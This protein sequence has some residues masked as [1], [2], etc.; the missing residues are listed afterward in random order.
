VTRLALATLLFAAGLQAEFTAV[1]EQD[2]VLLDNGTD[3]RVSIAPEHGGELSGIEIFFDGAWR[4]VVYRAD[5][6]S[7]FDG[8]RGKAPFLWPAVGRSLGPDDADRSYR[9]GERAYPMPPHGFARDRAWRVVRHGAGKTD[10]RA[11][12]ALMSDSETRAMYPFDFELRVE[13]RLEADRLAIEYTVHADAANHGPMPFCI[14]N[15]ITF[16]APLVDGGNP[17]DLRFVT[18][19]PDLLLREDDR[20]F[21]GRVGPSPWRGEQAVAAL[22][23][24]QAVSLGGPAGPAELTLTDPSGLRLTLRHA[25]SAEP[26]S[27]AI[28]FNLWSDTEEGF[29]SP[30]PWLGTQ[31][32]LNTGYGAVRLEPGALWSWRIEL[33]PSAAVAP[34]PHPNEVIP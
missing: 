18:D 3:L 9:I 6:Y 1:A 34:G 7:P 27:P 15:H 14:G 13:Y 20:T 31:N 29:F 11:V 17:G 16:R 28:R 30:E 24:R 8:W 2:R 4:E 25:A 12:L 5:D 22:P 10:A 19:L 32:C 33:I 26:A 23:R 21:R